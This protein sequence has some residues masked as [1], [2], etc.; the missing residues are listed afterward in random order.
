MINLHG[1]KILFLSV[2]FFN[3][4]KAIVNRLNELGAEVDFYDE[5]PSNS[6]FSKGIIRLNK[7][8]Y[9]LKINTYYNR[10]L[11]EIKDKKI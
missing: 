9:H 8:F 1:K 10:I 5:R 7:K 6:N 11:N 3:Y 2:S 4:E